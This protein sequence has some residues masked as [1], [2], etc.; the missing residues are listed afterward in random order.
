M[1]HILV[2]QMKQFTQLSES[3]I[4]AIAESFPIKTYETNTYLLKQGQIAKDAYLVIKGCIRKY[5][6]ADGEEITSDFFTEGYSAADFNSLS[7][8]KPSDYFF[9]CTEKTTVAVLNAEKEAALYKKFPRFEAICRIEFEKMMGEKADALEKFMRKS[10][11]EKYLDIL[12]Q[13]PGLINRVPQY[14]LASYLGVQ[15]ETL[16]RIRKRI[17]QKQ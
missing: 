1:A 14:Q 8:Q 13:R 15:P 10:P 12:E 2:E 17:V 11:E 9:C 7:H 6:I 4:L 16:S 3:E 5:S